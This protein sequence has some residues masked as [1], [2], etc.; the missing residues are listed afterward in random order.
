MIRTAITVFLLLQSALYAKTE[1]S[2]EIG[3]NLYYANGCAN[4]HG[5]N[6]EGSSYYP[7]LSNKKR[8]FL[9]KKLEDFKKG[10]AQTQKQEIMFTFAKPLTQA[11][12]KNITYFLA[13]FKKEDSRKYD[14]EEDLLGVDY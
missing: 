9:T 11:D 13:H 4:C 10:I 2:Y 3:K 14:V 5:T 12:I 6:A 1:T 7:K 8:D